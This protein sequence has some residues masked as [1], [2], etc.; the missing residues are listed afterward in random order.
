[1]F[2]CKKKTVN[3]LALFALIPILVMSVL[4]ARFIIPNKN[5]SAAAPYN[6][7]YQIQGSWKTEYMLT[8]TFTP[9]IPSGLTLVISDPN[10]G[11]LYKKAAGA[12]TA[13]KFNMTGH[14]V[15]VYCVGDIPVT[16]EF[17]FKV[18]A[19]DYQIEIVHGQKPIPT[20]I[21]PGGSFVYNGIC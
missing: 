3:R 7:V 16:K 18:T 12:A 21:R 11:E 9:N 13:V 8:D 19:K 4:S 1:M 10:G 20:L 6:Q 17:R 2:I 5:A 15:A 14:Y